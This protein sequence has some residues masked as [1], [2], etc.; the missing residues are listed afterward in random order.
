MIDRSLLL[1]KLNNGKNDPNEKF[2][3]RIGNKDYS[4]IVGDSITKDMAF[5]QDYNI[6]GITINIAKLSIYLEVRFLFDLL[7]KKSY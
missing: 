5:Q 4:L 7:R 6:N 3:L 1:T 2:I